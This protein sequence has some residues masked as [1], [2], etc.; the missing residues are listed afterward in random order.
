MMGNGDIISLKGGEVT[1][2]RSTFFAGGFAIATWAPMIPHVKANT[3]IGD[4]VLGIL[5]LCIGFSA[6]FTMP[7]AG[8]LNRIFGCRRMLTIVVGVMAADLLCLTQ[9]GSLWGYAAALIVFGGAMGIL[10]V[11]MNL[12]AVIVENAAGKRI[13]SGVHAFW[14]I[15][16]FCGAGLFTLLAFVGLEVYQIALCHTILLAAVVCIFFRRLLDYRGGGSEGMFSL[17]KGIIIMWGVLAGISFLG[18]GAI[19]DW[20]GVLLLEGKG[21]DR[22]YAG[23]AYAMYSVAMLLMRLIGDRA[24]Q[25]LGEKKSLVFGSLTAA[26]GFTGAA[27]FDNLTLLMLCFAVTGIGLAN[28]VPVLFSLLRFQDAMPISSALT[29]LT[30]MG[31]AGVIMGPSLLGF[32]SHLAGIASVFFLLALLLL[33]NMAAAWKFIPDR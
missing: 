26:V 2:A 19:M 23:S 20:S 12:N 30:T 5:L 14:S 11:I 6:F 22:E 29:A 10:D 8:S 13:M 28:I 31:Y 3:G 25:K 27:V 33:I 32:V 18:E 9:L 21:F 17:P 4:D 16:G 15:G 24:V 1:A 7:L